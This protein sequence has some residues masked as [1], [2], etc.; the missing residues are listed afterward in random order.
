MNTNN[1]Q[2]IINIVVFLKSDYFINNI[3]FDWQSILNDIEILNYK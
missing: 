1:I 3:L 2:F